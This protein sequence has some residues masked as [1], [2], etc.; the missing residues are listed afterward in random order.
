MGEFQESRYT[1]PRLDH[2]P[3]KTPWNYDRESNLGK[4][5]EGSKR[6]AHGALTRLR[7]KHENRRTPPCSI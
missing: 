7:Q 6:L 1:N 4:I 2:D 3:M 5:E